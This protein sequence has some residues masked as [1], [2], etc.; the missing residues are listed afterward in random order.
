MNDRDVLQ[1][2]LDGKIIAQKTHICPFKYRL[3]GGWMEVKYG[4]YEWSKTDHIPEL[5]SDYV[6]IEEMEDEE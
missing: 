4:K 5:D 2:L 3:N 1:A 6:K